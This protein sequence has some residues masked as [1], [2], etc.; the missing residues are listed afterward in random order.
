MS[1]EKEPLNRFNLSDPIVFNDVETF[2]LLTKYPFLNAANLEDSQIQTITVTQ[3]MAGN[4]PMISNK[5]YRTPMLDWVIVLFNKPLNP[6]NWPQT[7]SIIRAPIAEV[8]LPLV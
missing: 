1:I 2:G 3:E 8:V 4:P 6:V 5:L 7:G